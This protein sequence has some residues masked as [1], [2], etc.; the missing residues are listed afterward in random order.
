MLVTYNADIQKNLFKLPTDMK[1]IE[2]R[3]VSELAFHLA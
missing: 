2:L 3:R 1:K